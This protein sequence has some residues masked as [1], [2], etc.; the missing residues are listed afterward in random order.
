MDLKQAIYNS[1]MKNADI[2]T[3]EKILDLL[4]KADGQEEQERFYI[5]LGHAQDAAVLCKLLDFAMS[6]GL[7]NSAI[8]SIISSAALNVKNRDVVWN[9]FKENVVFFQKTFGEGT[10][11]LPRLVKFITENFASKEKAL[12]VDVFFKTHKFPGTERTVKQSIEKIHL[13]EAWLSKDIISI[14]NFFNKQ[15]K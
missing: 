13:N 5:A 6:K 14:N 2:A 10:Y 11:I 8:V 7:R 3:F 1:V 12:E 4:Q 15:S 9:Y